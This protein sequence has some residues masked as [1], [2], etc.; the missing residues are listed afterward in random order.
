ME[1]RA[2]CSYSYSPPDPMSRIAQDLNGHHSDEGSSTHTNPHT[3][4]RRI[5]PKSGIPR[6]CVVGAGIAGMRCA[7]VLGQKGIDVTIL[8]ARD[9]TGGRVGALRTH[10]YLILIS[11]KRC[12]CI[13]RC[14]A[15]TQWTS[16][17]EQMESSLRHLLR[18][19]VD[20]IGSMAS[21]RTRSLI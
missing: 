6:V 20:R 17:P 2:N 8:E 21:I 5:L 12:R 11:T 9:R 4:L 16:K 3:M 14:W 1:G 19:I 13:R 10:E 18:L 7:Q 15:D